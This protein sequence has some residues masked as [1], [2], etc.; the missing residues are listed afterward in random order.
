MRIN[1]SSFISTELI[2]D[3]HSFNLLNHAKTTQFLCNKKTQTR[4]K[5]KK[6]KKRINIKK[7]WNL[8]LSPFNFKRNED[9]LFTVVIFT[10]I[11]EKYGWL[12]SN[13][14]MIPSFH[15]P[16]ENNAVF[17]NWKHYRIKLWLIIVQQVFS[18]ILT[19]ISSRTEK[20]EGKNM[21]NSCGGRGEE[22][23]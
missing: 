1:N 5:R 15:L 18:T 13:Y 23:F 20:R 17:V 22:T 19:I 10:G 4:W 6:K 3:S 8:L 11:H 2:A 14:S 16:M 12:K 7:I 21:E 9:E